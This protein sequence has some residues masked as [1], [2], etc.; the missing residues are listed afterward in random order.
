MSRAVC[1]PVFHPGLPL[2]D[3]VLLAMLYRIAVEAREVSTF[4]TFVAANQALNEALKV[5]RTRTS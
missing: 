4:P 2:E 5:A 1:K 3:R